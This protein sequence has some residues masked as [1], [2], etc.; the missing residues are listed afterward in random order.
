LLADVCERE[1]EEEKARKEDDAEGSL[2][3]DAATDDDRVGEVGVEGH[4]GGERD[5][6]IGP[7]SHNERGDRG[8]NAGGE[9]DAFDGHPCFREDARIHDNHVGHGH[10][11]GEASEKF[12]ADGRLIFFEVEDALEQTGCPLGKWGQL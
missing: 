5:G 12:A 8:G 11:G 10:E 4:A 6:I 9:E 7:D 2:P 3:R 1:E